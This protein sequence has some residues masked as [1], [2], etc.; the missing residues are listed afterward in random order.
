VLGDR[1]K[2]VASEHSSRWKKTSLA[3]SIGKD[4]VPDHSRSVSKLINHDVQDYSLEDCPFL[5][6]VLSFHNSFQ[7]MC[8]D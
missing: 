5:N 8:A 3:T 6:Y 2:G 1:P 7:Q 4:K